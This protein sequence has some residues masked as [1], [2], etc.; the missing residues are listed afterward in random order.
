MSV[1]DEQITAI[2][3]AF[4]GQPAEIPVLTA[5]R[6]AAVTVVRGYESAAVGSSFARYHRIRDVISATPALAAARAERGVAR[7]EEAA[8]LIGARMG[9]DAHTDPRPRLVA[10]VA[11]GAVQTA[12]GAWRASEPDASD[13]ELI[14][15]AFDLIRAGID[16][17]AAPARP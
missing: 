14:G 2:L 7:L 6:E 12:V 10:S 4:A 15:R 16:Y 5:M 13:S 1:V 3:D 17:P 8:R 9:V 11:I